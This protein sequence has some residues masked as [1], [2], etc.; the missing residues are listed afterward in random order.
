MAPEDAQASLAKL[1]AELSLSTAAA[2]ERE[3]QLQAELLARFAETAELTRKL[4]ATR[5]KLSQ[6]RAQNAKLTTRVDAL[7]KS[8][9]YRIES[10]IRRRG[11]RTSA[12]TP[13]T[14]RDR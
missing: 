11:P 4:L 1:Q 5:R 7:E 8:V 9:G 6:A 10:L 2:A 12:D 14:K 3:E 13:T